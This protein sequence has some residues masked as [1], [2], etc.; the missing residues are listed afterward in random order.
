MAVLIRCGARAV[1]CSIRRRSRTVGGW[2]VEAGRSRAGHSAA[3]GLDV[4]SNLAVSP[5]GQAFP[6]SR[7]RVMSTAAAAEPSARTSG[8][9]GPA[10]AEQSAEVGGPFERHVN[11]VPYAHGPMLPP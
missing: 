9:R 6:Q 11:P 7:R 8:V 10:V 2:P 4:G 3:A 5:V 1:T